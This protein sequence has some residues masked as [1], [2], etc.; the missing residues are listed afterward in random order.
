MTEP[1]SI[2]PRLNNPVG[3]RKLKAFFYGAPGTG[4]TT[5]IGTAPKLL[6]LDVDGGAT[7]VR[8]QPNVTTF[9]VEKW[10]DLDDALFTLYRE[11][12]GFESV[13][14]DTLTTM[15]EVA[16]VHA[17]L[18]DVL[19]SNQDP[20]RAYSV[21]AAMARHKLSLF[22]SLDMHVLFTA[23]L[24]LKDG[25][26]DTADVEEGTFPLVPDIQ[27]AVQRTALA[28]PDIIGRTFLK[29]MGNGKLQH[30]IMFGPDERT[31]A[32]QRR[33]G[34]AREV[35]GLTIPK[36]IKITQTENIA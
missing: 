34:L 19:L 33:F 11:D 5:L 7:S 15:Q 21:M 25:P 36:L 24:R 31:V 29:D 27:P 28:L 20:R 8:G 23:H 9:R 35:T 26:D 1:K 13:A 30:A 32:K 2:L 17:K 10:G 22:H 4:K 16:A 3:P 12:H 14:I 6:L 18:H